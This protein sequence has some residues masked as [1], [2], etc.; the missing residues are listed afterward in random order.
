[1]DGLSCILAESLAADNLWSALVF[2]AA[3]VLMAGV[4]ARNQIGDSSLSPDEVT[5]DDGYPRYRWDS[6][7]GMGQYEARLDM[8]KVGRVLQ[9]GDGIARI[10][11]LRRA[12]QVSCSVRG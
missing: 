1:M 3:L 7:Q 6:E 2:L 5:C 8:V 12:W 11:G 9:V 4:R 10:H